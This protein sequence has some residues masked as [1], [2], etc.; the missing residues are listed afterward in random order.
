MRQAIPKTAFALLS[1]SAQ[2]GLVFPDDLKEP[3]ITVLERGLRF[4]TPWGATENWQVLG[5]SGRY[6]PDRQDRTILNVFS[7]GWP[8]DSIDHSMH[9]KVA[10][11]LREAGVRKILADSTVGSLNKFLQPRDFIIPRD[12]LDLSQT[13]YSLLDGRLRHQ[14]SAKQLFC[15]SLAQ[16]LE[17]IAR[18]LWPAPARVLGH[19]QHVIA[20]HNWGPRFSSQAEAQA[21][22]L[23]GGDAVNQ[24]IG[25][26]ASAAREIGAC[27]VSASFVVRYQDGI[28]E[29]A[30]EA[31][32]HLHHELARLAARISLLTLMRAP[33]TTACGCPGLHASRPA[34][35]TINAQGGRVRQSRKA[36]TR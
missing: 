28:L 35:Y 33:L 30:V 22:K 31:V 1:G 5:V 20:V 13:Q 2:W 7:H 16:A 17:G 10:W 3:G 27:F 23:L 4:E 26:E 24:S 29:G 25:P 6:T 11:V 36:R 9:R 14:C 34:G 8:T 32:D 19:G 12:V 18:E 15:P 21:Y